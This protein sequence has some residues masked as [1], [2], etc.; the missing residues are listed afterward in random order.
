M[1]RKKRLDEIM[2]RTRGAKSTNSTPKKVRLWV[3]F[4]ALEEVKVLKS[5]SP[6]VT[7]D[8]I[9]LRLLCL[10]HWSQGRYSKLSIIRPARSR[11]LEFE[12]KIVQEV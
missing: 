7:H 3:I 6:P 4:R 12:K 5:Y 11:L 9:F 10:R 2:A 8:R 1:A